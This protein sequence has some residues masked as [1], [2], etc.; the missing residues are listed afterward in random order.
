MKI[1]S[2]PPIAN[3]KSKILIL[4][5]MPGKDSLKF[6]EYYAHPRNTFWKLMFDVL[7]TPFSNDYKVKQ[8]LLLNNKIALWDI[9]ETCVREGS[10]DADILEEEPADLNTFLKTHSKIKHLLFNGKSSHAFFV[11]HTKGIS[12]P[13]TILPS[14][15]PAHAI[16]YEKK[17]AAWSSIKDLLKG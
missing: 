1:C 4:G 5:T 14:T 7:G 10:L 3:A 17:I 9:L 11:R 15:S 13:Y 12:L 16:P 6:N 2:F 8:S